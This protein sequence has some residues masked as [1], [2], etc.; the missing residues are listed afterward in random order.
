[1]PVTAL[2]RSLGKLSQAAAGA[3]QRCRA[4]GAAR[5][6]ALRLQKQR[7][8]HPLQ[9]LT[10]LAVYRTA[11]AC[12]AASS[13]C[14]RRPWSTHSIGPST[15]RSM[16]CSLGQAAA[17]RSRRVE[18]DGRRQV[19]GSPLTPREAAAAMALVTLATESEARVVA[20]C[21]RLVPL[22]LSPRQRST[23]R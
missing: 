17:H 7:R 2:L 8:V 6:N 13:G 5:L 4:A 10:A 23:M 22:A 14:R 21:D 20:F 3:R 15:A 11:M 1:M 16:A 9:V 18:L 19:A 12:S